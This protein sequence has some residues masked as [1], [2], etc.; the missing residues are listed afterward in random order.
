MS[1]F[2]MSTTDHATLLA[3]KLFNSNNADEIHAF[4]SLDLDVN[5]LAKFNDHTLLIERAF[6]VI[7][8]EDLFVKWW[9]SVQHHHP[10]VNV[11]TE[12][13]NNQKLVNAFLQPSGCY[14]F[15]SEL[16]RQHPGSLDEQM[17]LARESKSVE[18]AL[19][20]TWGKVSSHL[21]NNGLLT[22]AAN[23]LDEY[24]NANLYLTAP[25]LK[26]FNQLRPEVLSPA[27]AMDM[28]V[29]LNSQKVTNKN[30]W[31]V[32]EFMQA[33]W[34]KWTPEQWSVALENHRPGILM[35]ALEVAASIYCSYSMSPSTRSRYEEFATQIEKFY[36]KA[37][38]L[39][40]ISE[41]VLTKDAVLLSSS[42]CSFSHDEIQR[43]FYQKLGRGLQSLLEKASAHPSANMFNL[44]ITAAMIETKCFKT[45]MISSRAV[46]LLKTAVDLPPTVE[47]L[48]R[49]ISTEVGK[50]L[51][52]LKIIGVHNLPMLVTHVGVSLDG[53]A[54]K[55]FLNSLEDSNLY[56]NQIENI[57]LGV[58]NWS[59]KGMETAKTQ[60]E[61][62]SWANMYWQSVFHT[63]TA[64]QHYWLKKIHGIQDFITPVEC[65][66][67]EFEETLLS[68]LGK[69]KSNDA[70]QS[71]LSK[72][73][74]V[75]ATSE[76][77]LPEPV[78]RRSKM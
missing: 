39:G 23:A 1:N 71:V 77:G 46:E 69:R 56:R 50:G 31:Y 53:D 61:K 62:S 67:K 21:K 78:K 42:N 54:Q 11:W 18:S 65:W 52:S 29:R 63:Q 6:R 15:K 4:V 70:I 64:N 12:L 10:D 2:N 25:S 13:P 24:R 26:D 68:V 59:M 3:K 75:N 43:S 36:K 40:A 19:H 55:A 5:W 9:G 37:P 22:T 44:G 45:T 60:Q 27:N 35:N 30:L 17:A 48:C 57:S 20:P 72:M 28:Y 16:L 51:S 41:N 34:G 73:S 7:N 14:S 74:L 33:P 76:L 66:N 38:H 8:D 58:L 47:D 32:H 49:Q